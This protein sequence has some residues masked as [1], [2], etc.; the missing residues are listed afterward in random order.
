LS[1]RGSSAGKGKEDYGFIMN[2][3]AALKSGKIEWASAI[4]EYVKE[5]QL[6]SCVHSGSKEQLTLDHIFSTARG[7]S[8]V[9]DCCS[10]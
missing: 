1:P 7:R 10:S 8:D 4:R 2:R 5:W 9:S 6:E 3:F